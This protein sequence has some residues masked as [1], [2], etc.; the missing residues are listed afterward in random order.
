M[1][2]PK[3]ATWY[4]ETPGQRV[5]PYSIEQLRSLLEDGEV[6]PSQRVFPNKTS[7]ESVQIIRLL[8]TSEEANSDL[9]K[10]F[11]NIRE[12]TQQ[13]PMPTMVQR[14]GGRIPG[15]FWLIAA[16][17]LIVGFGAWGTWVF[18][19]KPPETTASS[20]SFAPAVQS[21]Q[22]TQANKTAPAT[23]GT[24]KRMPA[25]AN[26]ETPALENHPGMQMP[27]EETA[28]AAAVNQSHPEND[29]RSLAGSPEQPPNYPEP[30]EAN[31][32]PASPSIDPPTPP[33]PGSGQTDEFGREY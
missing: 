26:P 24:P 28:A 9:L 13:T 3:E 25:N 8:E 23:P 31:L 4:L 29:N 15:Q 20:T 21:P 1:R 22:N 14:M 12:K 30:I 7:N 17:V 11:Q 18:L 19:K 2:N 5:G 27:P 32:Q 6:Q 16:L 10:T 33:Q